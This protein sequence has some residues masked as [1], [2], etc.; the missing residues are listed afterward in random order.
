[1][2]LYRLIYNDRRWLFTSS[3]DG[4]R[5]NKISRIKGGQVPGRDLYGDRQEVGDGRI[6]SLFLPTHVSWTMDALCV[7]VSPDRR[8]RAIMVGPVGGCQLIGRGGKGS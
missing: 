7:S 4:G 5:W 3:V 1:M 2:C 8:G 6:T